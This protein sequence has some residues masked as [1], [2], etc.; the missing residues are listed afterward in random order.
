VQLAASVKL[1]VRQVERLFIR[2][3]GMTPDSFYMTL[4]LEWARELLRQTNAPILD[5]ALQTGF[6]LHSYFANSYR[7]QFHR[8]PSEERRTVH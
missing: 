5:A 3:L 6:D 1:S 7:T 4:R 2:H 8:S